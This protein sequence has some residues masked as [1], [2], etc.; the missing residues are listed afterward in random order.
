VNRYR[1]D[2]TLLSACA[3]LHAHIKRSGDGLS[4]EVIA[5]LVAWL[6]WRASHWYASEGNYD[7]LVRA[8]V[9]R[10]V[11]DIAALPEWRR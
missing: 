11:A 4:S 8:L 7:D 9:L 6:N 10:A 2:E 5:D 3:K 1:A